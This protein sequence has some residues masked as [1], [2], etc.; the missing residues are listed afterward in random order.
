MEVGG[1]Q[2]DRLLGRAAAAAAAGGLGAGGSLA[3]RRLLAGGAGGLPLPHPSPLKG[4]LLGAEGA[5]AG[6]AG[7]MQQ[8]CFFLP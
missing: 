7:T 8:R 4:R 3:S 2:G 6:G 5:G 1:E